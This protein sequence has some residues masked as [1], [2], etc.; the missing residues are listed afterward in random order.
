[1]LTEIL[2]TLKKERTFSLQELANRLNTDVEA[3][4]VQM[5]YLE[6]HGHIKRVELHIGC[7]S[8][9]GGCTGCSYGAFGPVMWELA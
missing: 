4:K 8:K 1:M 5:D 9:C 6:S 3:V 7:G 2:N